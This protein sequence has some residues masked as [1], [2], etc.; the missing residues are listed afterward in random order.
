VLA[1]VLPETGG[2]ALFDAV[3]PLSD[4]PVVRLMTLF[5]AEEGLLMDVSRRLRFANSVRD[6]LVAAAKADAAVDLAMTDAAGRA[7]VYRH[8]GHAFADAVLRRRAAAPDGAADA[9]R[10]LAIAEA[11]TP[12]RMPVGGRDLARLGVE[13]GPDTG[14]VL[15]AFED[16]WVAEDF[17]TDG[18]EARLAALVSPRRG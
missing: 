6:R 9:R 5:P 17:P 2:L 8:G 7:A 12:P 4:D 3:V 10:L 1:Q 11:W 16:Q 15:K 14:R 18:H 13:P